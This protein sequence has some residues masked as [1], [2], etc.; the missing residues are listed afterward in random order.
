MMSSRRS[1]VGHRG[2]ALFEVD[3]ATNSLGADGRI[4]GRG[5]TRVQNAVIVRVSRGAQ[6]A[7]APRRLAAATASGERHED[8]EDQRQLPTH[9]L[10]GISARHR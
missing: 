9:R 3:L 10:Q 7:A 4:L 6:G 8:G 1:A 2:A 5:V